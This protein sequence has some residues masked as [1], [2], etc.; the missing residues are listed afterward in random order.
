[1]PTQQKRAAILDL[2]RANQ[3]RR[4]SLGTRG[5]R[6]DSSK[7]TQ[8]AI[9]LNFRISFSSRPHRPL[10]SMEVSREDCVAGYL[11]RERIKL[12][13]IENK[14]KEIGN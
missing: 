10:P 4:W 3:S 5:A 14:A 9:K 12:P 7:M 6:S 8:H 11:N 1:M 13:E 2:L